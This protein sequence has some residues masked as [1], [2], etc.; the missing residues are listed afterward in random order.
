[1]PKIYS[2]ESL[3]K[4][5][6]DHDY[7]INRGISEYTISQFKGGVVKEGKMANRYVFPIFNAKDD[8]VG[9]A[10]RDLKPNEKRPKWKLIGD[11]SKWKYPLFLNFK[12]IR[13][14][15]SII[16][17]ESIGDMLALWD[18]GITNVVVAFGLGLS[19]AL[20]GVFIRL[21]FSQIII[22]FN[23]DSQNS[24]AGNK[25]AEKAEQKLLN[26]FDPHQIRVK[27]PIQGDFGE[28]SKEQILTWVG[29]INEQ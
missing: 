27:L 18:C 17:V 20:M 5:V 10:G 4:L 1:M 19:P 6:P 8:I 15:K 25:A 7:W 12:L 11:K 9:F 16:I 28:M 2:K 13:K 29:E 22:S 14:E 24:N 23:D 3:K 26:Y 21:D